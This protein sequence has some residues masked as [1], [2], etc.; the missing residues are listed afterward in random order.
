MSQERNGDNV[1]ISIFGGPGG[2][3]QAFLVRG[4]RKAMGPLQL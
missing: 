2:L 4:L 1:Q 3:A